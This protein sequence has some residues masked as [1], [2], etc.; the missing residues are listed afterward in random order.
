MEENG[1]LGAPSAAP[2]DVDTLD[3]PAFNG[4]SRSDES[5]VAG[6]TALE[7]AKELQMLRIGVVRSEPGGTGYC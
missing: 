2:P 7:V 1:G 5:G 4:G 3:S 6:I